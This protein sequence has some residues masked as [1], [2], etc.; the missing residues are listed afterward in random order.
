MKC[1]FCGSLNLKVVDKRDTEDSIRRRRGCLDCNKRFTT[2]EKIELTP[3]IVIKKDK[4]RRSFDL[5]KIKMGLIKAC[6]KRPISIEDIDVM[7]SEIE[8]RLR[9]KG[10]P[11]INSREIGEEIMDVL[12]EKDKIS[13]IRFASVYREFADLNDFKVEMKKL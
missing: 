12:K 13:Y 8:R 5:N 7:C 10:K 11:E 1:P 3:L 2:Y 6:E 4:T 9:E